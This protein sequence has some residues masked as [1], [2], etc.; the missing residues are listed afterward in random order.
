MKKTVK[1]SISALASLL[2]ATLVV[3]PAGAQHMISS[4]AGFVNRTEGKVYISRHD[5]AE[6]EKGRASI[7]TQMKNGDVVSTSAGALAEILLNP[8]SY[9]RMNENTEVRALDTSLA[10]VRFEVIKG[11]VIFEV[12]EAD[13]KAPI[14]IVTPNGSLFAVKAG[15]HRIDVKETGT[16][17]S[18]RQGEI[19]LGEY[20][21]AMVNQGFKIKRGKYAQLTGNPNPVL[22]KIDKDKIDSFD[23]WSFNRASLLMA[24]NQMALRQAGSSTLAYGWNYVPFSN[25][26]TFI[27]RRGLF[28]SPYGFG[29]FSSYGN[30][31]ACYGSPYGY[32]YGYGY[33]WPGAGS[34]GGS[35]LP[36]R[37]VAGLDRAPI[38]RQIEG[39]RVDTGSG[40]SPGFGG[41]PGFSSRGVSSSSGS[42]S[43]T[44]STIS[45]PAPSRGDTSGGGGGRSLP[46]R[47]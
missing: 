24:A 46:T 37:V 25:C 1:N 41:D 10:K 43:G 47:P 17:V 31:F 2:L 14:E 32:G 42:S 21:Q 33:G 39:R 36:P 6:N 26:Y 45:A 3:A 23:T 13:K 11:T 12:G 29:F 27:P 20:N 34:G 4:K 35:N 8:G 38:M 22:A 9:L 5:A 7:G 44:T 16:L 18:A 28:Y 15:L 30:C 19:I 40:S